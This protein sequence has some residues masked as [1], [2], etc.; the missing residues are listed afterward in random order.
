MV[1]E[2][3]IEDLL[4]AVD[5]ELQK[6]VNHPLVDAYPEFKEMFE[7][8]LGW[9]G[10]GAGKAAQGK[11]LRPL[12]VLLSAH[13]AGGD[14]KSALPASAAVELM[15]NFSLIHDDIQDQSPL[16]RGRETIWVK[17]GIAQA[18]NAGDAMLGLADL[19]LTDMVRFFPETIVLNATRI[20]QQTLLELTRGQYLDLA[21]ENASRVKM[22]DYSIMVEGKT[23][24][25]LG[26]CMELGAIFG[27]ATKTQQKQ[28]A[29]F[30][31]TVGNAFQ[32]QDD[33]LGIWG[34]DQSTGKPASV[35]LIE[36]KKSY[37]ILLGLKRKE[38]FHDLWMKTPVIDH[39]N[40]E[41]FSWLLEQE[42]VK[43][44]TEKEF[45]RIYREAVD[46]FEKIDFNPDRKK[47]LSKLVDSILFR[48]R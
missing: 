20:F 40:Y 14:W 15:H 21:Y 24:A 23:G 7:Y 2:L 10:D 6:S 48:D 25:L 17:W 44:D 38:K 47:P 41:E 19:T 42:G 29:H 35:D 43:T 22:D 1:N 28:M 45:T 31:R 33:W 9:A 46:L 36:R 27:G 5:A 11:R 4:Q 39:D 30:G 26:C 37:P 12:I 32:I 18:I 13:A 8:Q 16:R 3:M 34:K